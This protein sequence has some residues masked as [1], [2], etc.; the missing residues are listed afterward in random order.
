MGDND[1][2]SYLGAALSRH[3]RLGQIYDPS[4]RLTG[5]D[6]N[7]LIFVNDN[8]KPGARIMCTANSNFTVTSFRTGR[9]LVTGAGLLG[10]IGIRRKTV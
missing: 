3:K 4:V 7:Y 8:D 10:L 9:G 1:Q 5:I 6:F 2:Y